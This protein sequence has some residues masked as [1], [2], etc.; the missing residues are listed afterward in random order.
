MRLALAIA[1]VGAAIAAAP[2]N[3]AP[4]ADAAAMTRALMHLPDDVE[5]PHIPDSNPLTPEKIALGRKLFYDQRLSAN[6][7]QSCSSCH[8]QAKAFSDGQVQPLGSTGQRLKRNAQALFNLAYLPNYTWASSAIVS[9]ETQIPI[10][11]RSERPPELGINDG[12]ADAVLQRFSDDASYVAMFKQAF[13]GS[14]SGPTYNKIVFALASF[15]RTMTSFGSRYDLYLAGHTEALTAQEKRGLALFNGERL[16]CFHC[17]SG[18]ALTTSYVDAT[19]AADDRPF[20][21]FSNGI[22]NVGDAGTYPDIDHGLADATL[23]PRHEGL[24]R[25]P[26]LRNVAVT[27]PYMH[28]GSI[29][30][31]DAVIDSYAAGGRVIESGPLAGDGRLFPNKSSFVRGF[32]LSDEEKAALVAFLKS[33]TDESFL[34]RPDLAAPSE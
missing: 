3:A 31:L 17:H 19:R 18:R 9:L 23:N 21:F 12:N 33:L 1:F 11:M 29:A 34:T 32:T 26:S 15:L 14:P 10:P 24:F 27:A 22:Y 20:V 6:E 4:A 16:E 13:P 5:L 28:D 8:D 25:P 7:T 2:T 30:T